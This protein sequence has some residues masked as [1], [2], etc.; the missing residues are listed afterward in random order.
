MTAPKKDMT[1]FCIMLAVGICWAIGAV[2]LVIAFVEPVLRIMA[3]WKWLF[4]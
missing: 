2:A 4:Q 1:T 3:L